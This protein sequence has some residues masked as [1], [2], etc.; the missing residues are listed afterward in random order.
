MKK[1]VFI[2]QE[3]S[4]SRDTRVVLLPQLLLDGLTATQCP[5]APYYLVVCTLSMFG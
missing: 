1:R 4:L 2:C 5:R 3:L